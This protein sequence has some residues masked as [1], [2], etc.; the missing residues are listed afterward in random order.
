MSSVSRK[1]GVWWKEITIIRPSKPSRG[2]EALGLEVVITHWR[3][4]KEPKGVKS[5]KPWVSSVQFSSVAQSCPTLCDP[6]NCSTPGLP[7]HHQLPQFTQTHF[8]RVS[9]AIQ[10]PHPLSSPSSPASESFPLSQLFTWGGQSTGVSAL[11]SFLPKKSHVLR[12][13]DKEGNRTILGE[14]SNPLRLQSRKESARAET[15]GWAGAGSWWNHIN[16]IWTWPLAQSK[17]TCPY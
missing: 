15:G 5:L 2:G 11:A 1:L 6:M 4:H 16:V 12:H 3:W 7:V 8:H 10:P 17:W 14:T 13:A 9:D